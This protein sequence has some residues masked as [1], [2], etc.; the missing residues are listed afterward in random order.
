VSLLAVFETKQP[1]LGR[2]DEG[3]AGIGGMSHQAFSLKIPN[4]HAHSAST[5]HPATATFKA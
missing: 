5:R 3:E 1:T 4:K 2:L